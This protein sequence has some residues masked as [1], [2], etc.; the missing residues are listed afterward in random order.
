ME[1]L[2]IYR[3]NDLTKTVKSLA[4]PAIKPI[5]KTK[6]GLSGGIEDIGNFKEGYCIK[7]VSIAEESWIVIIDMLKSILF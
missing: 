5:V 4:M 7:V 3:R 2:F 1:I 6:R